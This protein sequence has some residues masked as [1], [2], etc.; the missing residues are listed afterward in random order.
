MASALQMEKIIDTQKLAQD[1]RA[2]G[3]KTDARPQIIAL[4]KDVLQQGRQKI[5]TMLIEEGKG[6][7][8]ARRLSVLSDHIIKALYHFAAH[9]LYPQ[10]DLSS[11]EQIA[12]IAVGGYGRGTLA[13]GSDL[14][15]YFLLADKQTPNASPPD[16]QALRGEQVMEYILYMLWDCGLK[17]SHTTCTV[18]EAIHLAK[19][20]MTARTAL[21]EARFLTG[22]MMLFDRLTKC[23]NDEIIAGTAPEFI[24]AKLIE[25]DRRHLKQG[26]TRYLVEP[27]IKEGKGGQR[28]LHM[29][30]WIAQYFYHVRTPSALTQAGILSRHEASIFTKADDFLWAVR[31]H[32]HFLNQCKAQERLSFDIQ[33]DIAR[34]LGYTRHPGQQDVERFMKHYFLVAK[35]VGDLTRI[36][37]AALEDAHVKPVVK[38]VVKP[39][40]KPDIKTL[41]EAEQEGDKIAEMDDFIIENQ[42]IN[43]KSPDVF[44]KN[45]LQLLRIFHLADRLSLQLHPQAMQ[46]ISRSLKLVNASLREDKTANALFLDLLTSPHHPAAMLRQMNESGLLGKFIPDFGRIVAMMQFSMYHHYTVDEHL[47][48]CIGHLSDIE[49]GENAREH[50]LATSLL[51]KIKDKRRILYVALLLH[52][53]AKGRREDHS[54]AGAR[55]AQSLCPRLGLDAQETQTV[56]WLVREHL[57]MS[58][59][60]QSRDLND[61]KTITDFA[62][63]V[64]TMERL[65]L[66]LIL[67]ICDIKAVGPG[68][69]N[70]WKGELLR[71]LYYATELL[72][73]GGF[74]QLPRE[75]ELH[76]AK[77]RLEDALADWDKGA[78]ENYLALHYSNYW[79][80]VPLEEQIAHADFI[81]KSD[82]AEEKLAIMTK[83]HDFEAVTELTILAQDHPRLLSIVAG[84]CAATDA[85]IVDAQIFTTSDGRALDMI[86]IHRSFAEDEDEYRRAARIAKVI[87]DVLAGQAQLPEIIAARTKRKRINRTFAHV[88]RV[89]INND[90]SEKFSVIEI[91]GLDRLG[92]L[93]EITAMLADLALDI[94]SAQISTFGEKIRDSF[95]VTDLAGNKI[96]DPQQAQEICSKL[97]A[98]FPS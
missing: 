69:W 39:S 28:D 63:K 41:H 46:Q 50:P 53:I 16:K 18:E 8:C 96:D 83:L 76:V 33:R 42:R 51:P 23:F 32:M 31:A 84:A 6:R 66:L 75:Q 62:A 61:R 10:P 15:L 97:L 92:L 26:Q 3:T 40:P 45:P 81:R 34:R 12:L 90:V 17:V 65:D 60:A 36:I 19:S 70:G 2:I 67:T 35:Q 58:E 59:V 77:A 4:L 7:L 14:D 73:S 20:D 88:P 44:E 91:E 56:V 64:E 49:R 21:L 85:N 79:L 43:I 48:R 13:P 57:T 52:D 24:Q 72:L 47:L 71:T 89:D 38:P 78:R 25:R 74:S 9:T 5:E 80:S 30:F 11:D 27:N 68:V 1:L 86:L 98:L 37:C 87:E 22:D 29:L 94:A 95:Y 82:E 55:I 93:S 54:V